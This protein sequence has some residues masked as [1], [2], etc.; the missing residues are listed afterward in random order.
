[1]R[2]EKTKPT[3]LLHFP[4]EPEH[5]LLC[6][7]KAFHVEKN[8]S[9]FALRSN[10]RASPLETALS[11]ARRRRSGRRATAAGALRNT[12]PARGSWWS[13]PSPGGGADSQRPAGRRGECGSFE[14]GEPPL[15]LGLPG[16]AGWRVRPDTRQSWDSV[17]GTLGVSRGG[18]PGPG[19]A[20]GAGGGRAHVGA[21]GRAAAGCGG[22]GV[23][24]PPP[25]RDLHVCV[26]AP[27]FLL[28]YAAG[29][30]GPAG[31]AGGRRC[32]ETRAPPPP[33]TSTGSRA[34]PRRL[35]PRGLLVRP[36]RAERPAPS[37]GRAALGL[38]GPLGPLPQAWPRAPGRPY[39]L[40]SPEGRSH[41]RDVQF[42]PHRGHRLPVRRGFRQWL[43]QHFG[44]SEPS[45]RGCGRGG[46]EWAPMPVACVLPP[47]SDGGPGRPQPPGAGERLASF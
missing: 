30:R 33:D 18:R 12:A 36:G 28:F 26:A 8:E 1:M 10:E 5:F 42:P 4:S 44:V 35:P 13:P 38:L 16:M 29:T 9:Q 22:R 43:H 25:G 11:W 14:G 23:A 15:Q 21:G 46:G 17:P 40:G 6:N 47:P 3:P 31:R 45:S 7:E 37:W 24:S 32:A 27:D 2:R 19:P 20:R 34:V 41:E 39:R